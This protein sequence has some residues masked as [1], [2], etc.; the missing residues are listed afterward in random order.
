VQRIGFVTCVELGKAVLREI[1]DQGGAVDAIVTLEDDQ[2]RV[3][4]G[5]VFLDDTAESHG[6][7]LHKTRNINDAATLGWLERQRLDWLFI[8]GWSQIASS[9]VLQVARYGAV[10]MHPTLLPA[11]RGRAS[12]PWAI[13]KG[14]P[15]TGVTLF[16][17]DEGVDSG[18]IIDQ[19]KIPLDDRETAESLYGKVTRAH[20]ELLARNWVRF[21]AG[22]VPA[23]PQD[24]SRA[25]Y[26]PGRGPADGEIVP[27]MTVCEADRLVRA[28]TRPYPGAFLRSGA[29]Q[30]LRVWQAQPGGSDADGVRVPLADGDLIA[31]DFT[32]ESVAG[33]HV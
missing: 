10:G 23:T 18:P 27:S 12:I 30:V 7:G 13:L 31:T 4:S 29:A 33:G 24:E 17:L 26:W 21:G 22:D 2:G 11:G 20:Q 6:A 19:A 32:F 14:L 28:V 5:R 8:I 25:T 3:K 9:P 1:L 15:E 16:K